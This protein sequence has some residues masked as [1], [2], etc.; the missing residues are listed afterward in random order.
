MCETVARKSILFVDQLNPNFKAACRDVTDEIM[1]ASFHVV[2]NYL[3]PLPNTNLG[4]ARH[5]DQIPIV[6]RVSALDRRNPFS[7]TS[8]TS[9]FV[10]WSAQCKRQSF[11]KR[12]Q[13]LSHCRLLFFW[14]HLNSTHCP[15]IN[16]HTQSSAV[17]TFHRV[18]CL[19]RSS[20]L[21]YAR[22]W[23]SSAWFKSKT[24]THDATE[25][26]YWRR[27]WL[28]L[29]DVRD[30]AQDCLRFQCRSASLLHHKH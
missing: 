16:W 22:A 14:R 17:H 2:C 29:V 15:W 26:Q 6:Q 11:V 7:P 13:R 19:A 24:S 25:I 12:S 20:L 23:L 1:I 30:C 27:P 5:F 4:Y 8:H 21:Q 28:F 18:W 10:F 3:Q 9:P